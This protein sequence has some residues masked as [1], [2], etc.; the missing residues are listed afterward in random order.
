MTS[1]WQKALPKPIAFVLSAGAAL[2]A[3]QTGMLKALRDIGLYPDLVVGGIGR[4]SQW[5][6]D[7]QLWFG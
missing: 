4:C 7:R 6:S 3:M 1:R 5:F 2:G